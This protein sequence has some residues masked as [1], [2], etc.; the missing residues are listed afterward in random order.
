MKYIKK[1]ATAQV[2]NIISKE[3]LDKLNKRFGT[4]YKKSD[5]SISI[6][7]LREIKKLMEEKPKGFY[8]I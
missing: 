3:N 5:K 7:R 2:V 4:N 1:E 8:G 6:L